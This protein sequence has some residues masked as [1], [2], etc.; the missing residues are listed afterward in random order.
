MYCALY[1][2]LFKDKKSISIFTTIFVILLISIFCLILLE[3]I[4][5]NNIKKNIID[6]I[7]N[8]QIVIELE[9]EK[10]SY[11]TFIK[12]IENNV[13]FNNIEEY[14]ET[15]YS[16]KSSLGYF[17]ISKIYN[18]KIKIVYGEKLDNHQ[19]NE[20][21]LPEKIEVNGEKID[22]RKFV[23]STIEVPVNIN[24]VKTDIKLYVKGIYE[25]RDSNV[26]SDIYISNFN[27][28]NNNEIKKYVVTLLTGEK[29]DQQISKL[30]NDGLVSYMFDYSSRRELS[31]YLKYMQLINTFIILTIIIIGIYIY[32]IINFLIRKQ[33]YN[34]ALMK[35]YG[36]NIK[37]IML[38]VMYVILFI[39]NISFL[40]FFL[41][42]NLSFFIL[43]LNLSFMDIY[44]TFL[45]L[46]LSINIMTIIISLLYVKR[47]IKIS[48]INL[49]N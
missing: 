40:I 23:G 41:T 30:K 44:I 45:V 36:Y 27:S 1:K 2:S 33:T 37:Q 26:V 11:S 34:I 6:K 3:K 14:F 4:S 31:T 35:T 29:I 19:K 10:M 25:N 22:T 38:N 24:N 43:K 32:F 21:L 12:K 7:E 39:I 46:F 18:E 42:V 49:L 8:R 28:S 20:I 47:I 15:I 9:Q 5:K 17:K 16:L 13:K 48:V